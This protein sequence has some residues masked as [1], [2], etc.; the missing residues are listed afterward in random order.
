[1]QEQKEV[2]WIADLDGDLVRCDYIRLFFVF[3]DKESDRC[4]IVAR[5][6][7]TDED[8]SPIDH[9]LFEGTLAQCKVKM[10]NLSVL[11]GAVHL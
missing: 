9:Y 3:E 1:M 4:C 7:N 11:L 2:T 6:D 5:E 10:Q 8:D